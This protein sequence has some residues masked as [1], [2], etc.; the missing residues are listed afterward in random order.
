M[1]RTS[2]SKELRS[3]LISSETDRIGIY[4]IL[5]RNK[6]V[7]YI[8]EGPIRS[9]LKEHDAGGVFPLIEGKYYRTFTT[10]NPELISDMKR[11]LIDDYVEICGEAP[12]YNSG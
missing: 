2:I 6:R 12:R 4:E 5:D 1:D 8:G 10:I 7:L 3:E 11:K 9:M